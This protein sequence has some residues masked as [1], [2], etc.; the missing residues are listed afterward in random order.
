MSGE[1]FLEAV[2]HV[3]PQAVVAVDEDLIIRLVSSAAEDLLDI[4]AE[5]FVGRHIKDCG[6]LGQAGLADL[7]NTLQQGVENHIICYL[8]REGNVKSEVRL[9]T[10]RLQEPGGKTLGA[11]I[12]LKAPEMQEDL[13]RSLNE[14]RILLMRHMASGIAHHIRNSITAVRGFV[15]IMKSKSSGEPISGFHE[16]SSIAVKEMDRV[17]DIISNILHLADC[18]EIN[19][20]NINVKNMIDNVVAFVQGKAALSGIV[21]VR[22][23]DGQLPEPSVDVVKIINALFNILDNAIKAMPGGGQLIIKAYTAKEKWLCIEIAD[24]GTGIAPEHVKYIFDPFYTTRDEAA[25][26]GLPMANKIIYDHGGHIRVTSEEGN[27]STFYI[28]LPI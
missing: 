10:R 19:K 15:Q 16:F 4:G 8:F 21:I 25:G 28:Y 12:H 23:I 5:N 7:V 27:G 11:V 17:N 20:E 9:H 3:S 6:L 1:T 22:E 18:V 24:T 26:L 2:V 14:E 13:E